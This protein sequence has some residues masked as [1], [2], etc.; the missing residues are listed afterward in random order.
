MED[1]LSLLRLK[2]FPRKT[3]RFHGRRAITPIR[4]RKNK[5]YAR[6]RS[7]TRVEESNVVPVLQRT[8][9]HVGEKREEDDKK[10]HSR[11]EKREGD[12]DGL[13]EGKGAHAENDEASDTQGDSQHSELTVHPGSVQ[14]LPTN[15]SEGSENAVSASSNATHLEEEEPSF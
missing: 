9:S 11:C 3:R 6:T 14:G 2:K 13:N 1:S 10:E 15:T 12:K 5:R 8:D 7:H 4:N